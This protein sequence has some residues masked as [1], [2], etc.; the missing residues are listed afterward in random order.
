M[1]GSLLDS[2]LSSVCRQHAPVSIYLM[3]GI[4]LQG[5]IADFDQQVILLKNSFEQVVFRHSIATVVPGCQI[6]WQN[7]DEDDS[8]YEKDD[9]ELAL[10]EDMA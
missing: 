2:F 10:E 3:S 5:F 7:E 6:I 1:Q 4:K 8:F 9:L